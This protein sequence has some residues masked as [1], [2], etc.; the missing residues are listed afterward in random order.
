MTKKIPDFLLRLNNIVSQLIFVAAFSLLFF[1]I[2]HP[3]NSTAWF[4]DG[5]NKSQYFLA[6]LVIVSIG[7]GIISLS[8]LLMYLLR[9]RINYTYLNY[10]LW[11]LSEIVCIAFVY[12]IINKYGLKDS[13]D[14]FD[15]YPKAL[16]NTTLVL[17]I[18][19]VVSWLYLSLQEKNTHLER[20]LKMS[21]YI[22]NE[23]YVEVIPNK[24][25]KINFHDERGVLILSINFGSL[26]YIESAENY[27]NI[28]YEHKGSISKTQ[29]RRNLKSI[30]EEFAEYPLIRCHRSYIVNINKINMIKKGKDGFIIDFDQKNIREI[31]ISKTYS[32]QVLNT[33]YQ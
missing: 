8:R 32:D 6:S 23:N 3:F 26:F 31:P 16:A 25:S 28:Y 1:N 33:F 10:G 12:S 13:R 2:Y 27:T 17:L 21:K 11:I 30:E 22:E 5:N 7:I 18:P 20:A 14:I 4:P 29:L 15:A 9:K 24:L 19:Y